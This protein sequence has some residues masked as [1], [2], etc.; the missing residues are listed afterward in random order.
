MARQ[1][2]NINL[3][4]MVRDFLN[5]ADFTYRSLGDDYQHAIR[6]AGL[7]NFLTDMKRR[8][9]TDDEILSTLVDVVQMLNSG[10]SV[11]DI[12]F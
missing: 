8:G 5:E 6:V 1:I 3:R 9:H 7:K 11:E 10:M 12:S 4:E 2:H